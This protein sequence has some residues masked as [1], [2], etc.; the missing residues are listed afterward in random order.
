[1]SRVQLLFTTTNLPL[2]LLIRAHSGGPFSHVALVDGDRVIEAAA[3]HGVRE[4][5]LDTALA[6]S[7]RAALMS[8]PCQSAAAV[9][10]AARSQIGKRYDWTGIAGFGLNRDWQESDAWFCSELAAWSFNA[11]GQPLIRADSVHAVAVQHLWVLPHAV[12][13][14]KDRGRLLPA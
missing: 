14:I 12:T 5:S 3:G 9:L 6:R 13:P 7:H 4:A 11:A 8:V 2:S 10:A 1:M